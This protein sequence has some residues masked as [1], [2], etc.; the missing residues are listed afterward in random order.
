MNKHTTTDTLAALDFTEPPVLQNIMFAGDGGTVAL[1]LRD[2]S[3]KLFS[4][5]F[6]QTVFL[7]KRA[8]N[9]TPGSFTLDGQEVAIRSAAEATLLAALKKMD[10][11]QR[12]ISEQ[13]IIQERIAF[14]ESP[15]Y[16]HIAALMGRM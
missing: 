4:I 13:E 1:A 16:L 5:Y 10:L 12:D 15:E 6:W 14:V 9:N 2:G 8:H 3:S 7:E 11:S